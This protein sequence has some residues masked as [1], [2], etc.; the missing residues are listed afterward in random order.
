VWNPAVSLPVEYVKKLLK[1]AASRTRPAKASKPSTPAA[2][3]A[4]R[5]RSLYVTDH[6]SLVTVAARLGVT[7]LTVQRWK[8]K[9]F[10]AGDDW[11]AARAAARLKPE[12]IQGQ[13]QESLEAFLNYHRAALDEVYAN[14]DM[15]TAEKVA[16]V[17]S[18]ADAYT[19]HLRACA[20]T[21]P[22]INKLAVAMDVLQRLTQYIQD[23]RPADV[24]QWLG[25]VDAFGSEL[26][27]L[28]GQD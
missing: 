13:A 21:M 16:A 23:K 3:D 11:D 27:R 14:K 17:T 10:D 6:L 25:I 26:A 8:A 15:S 1:K 28:Y 19:K 20:V 24:D 7:G 9:A 12:T 4:S 2:P 18:L 22:Q 5:A